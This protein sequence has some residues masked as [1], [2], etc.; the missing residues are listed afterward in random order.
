MTDALE[1]TFTPS[2]STSS[3]T[4]S[5]STSTA[6][7]GER[8][9][10][11]TRRRQRDD[12]ERDEHLATASGPKRPRTDPTNDFT[13][14]SAP[15]QPPFSSTLT[16]MPAVSTVPGIEKTDNDRTDINRARTTETRKLPQSS[17]RKEMME[18]LKLDEE[19]HLLLLIRGCITI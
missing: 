4:C 7:T 18:Y 1:S 3:A 6:T 9:G 8:L 2:S 12:S 13:S 16:G 14:K 11:L 17:S 15:I 10:V 19:T 5:P